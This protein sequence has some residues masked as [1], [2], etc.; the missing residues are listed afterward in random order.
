MAMLPRFLALMVL[1]ACVL[2]FLALGSGETSTL[3]DA[4]PR[5]PASGPDTPD[6]AAG[7]REPVLA[8]SVYSVCYWS[9]LCCHVPAGSIL[10]AVNDPH[11]RHPTLQFVVL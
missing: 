3:S 4:Q 6:L 2:P 8:T 5:T 7:D 9:T 1:S 10:V 11:P